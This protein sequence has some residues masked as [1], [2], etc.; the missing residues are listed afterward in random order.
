M[1]HGNI[2]PKVDV[3]ITVINKGRLGRV[4]RS[5]KDIG[6]GRERQHP[7]LESLSMKSSGQREWLPRLACVHSDMKPGESWPGYFSV[8]VCTSL[9]ISSQHL[10]CRLER[11]QSTAG[12]EPGMASHPCAAV[13]LMELLYIISSRLH[14]KLHV[15][16]FT[17]I[18]QRTK[19]SPGTFK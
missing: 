16:I 19:L 5:G 10:I 3:I 6:W 1:A 9:L 17:P 7:N 2:Q 12:E 13:Q 8:M 14:H 11:E 18:L 4:P 15:G